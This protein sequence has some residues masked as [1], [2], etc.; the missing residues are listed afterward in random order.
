M[1]EKQTFEDVRAEIANLKKAR[2]HPNIVNLFAEKITAENHYLFFE[3]CN[4]GT[5]GDIKLLS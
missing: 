1:R 5:L 3:L 2:H 4:G